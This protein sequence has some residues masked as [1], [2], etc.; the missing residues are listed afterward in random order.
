MIIN[1]INNY[2]VIKILNTKLDVYNTK[3]LENI[4]VNI[5][6]KLNQKYKIKNYIH[7][8]FYL[9]NNYGIITKLTDYNYP[10]SNNK[11][12]T[13][14]LTI[15]TDTP[16]LYKMDYFNIKENNINIKAIYYY[17]NKFYLEINNNIRKKDYL[18]LLELSEVIYEE[19]YDIIDNGIKI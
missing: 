18:E 19:T 8:E 15:H 14:K 5:I 10:L 4:T 2:Y 7:L 3:E 9:N 12:K 6:K 16:F 1:K 11:E 17:K 13:V